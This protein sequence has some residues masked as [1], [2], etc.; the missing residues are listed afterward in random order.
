MSHVL[1]V[2][3]EPRIREVVQYALEREGYR[4]STA[5]DAKAADAALRAEAIDLVVLDIMLPDKSGLELCRALRE[6]RRT[7]VLFLSARGEEIDRI[8][9]LEVGGDDYLPKPF[10][11]RELV[12]RV[13]AVLRRSE[14]LDAPPHRSE[15]EP[16]PMPTPP[17]SRRA[18]LQLG[19]LHIDIER[20]E[21]RARGHQVR[22]THTEFCILT[23]LAERPGVVFS[24]QQL[25]TAATDE[26]VHIAERTIDTHVRRIRSKLREHGLS[27]VETVHGVGYKLRETP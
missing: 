21:L 14:P 20:H 27:P 25:I 1:V 8:I 13:R 4:V 2:D 15:P 12:A 22:L 26:G 24:R 3:D 5:T 19:E 7:P 16:Q 11:P 10:S 9:G 6:K 23:A 18:P 17:A